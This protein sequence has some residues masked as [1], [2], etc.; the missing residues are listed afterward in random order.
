MQ[1]NNM[2]EITYLP[3]IER[4]EDK[5]YWGECEPEFIDEFTH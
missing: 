3:M 5:K 4:L 2:M 1:L